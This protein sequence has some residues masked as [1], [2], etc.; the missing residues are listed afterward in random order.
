MERGIKVVRLVNNL[1]L[2]KLRLKCIE[3]IM[4]SLEGKVARP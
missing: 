2:V 1:K 4:N 3:S